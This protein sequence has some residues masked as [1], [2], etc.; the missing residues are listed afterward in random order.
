[1]NNKEVSPFTPGN[2]VPVEFFVGRRDK[3]EEIL[4]YIKQTTSGKQEN[5]FLSGERSI[6]KSSLAA[7]I[8]HFAIAKENFIGVH[9]FLGGVS[10]L[11]ELVRRIFDQLLKETRGQTLFNNII[12]LF[13][14]HIKEIGLFG[15][16]VSFN[17]PKEDLKDLVLNFSSALQNIIKKVKNE[18][19]GLFITLDD[20][21]GLA[22]NDA[23][24]NW[25][26]SFV[27]EVATHYSYFPVFIMTVGL[28]E[29]RDS[30]SK[31]QPS[32]M[33]I[34]RVVEI[35]KLQDKEVKEFFLRTFNK[36]N[37]KVES[38]AMEIMIDFSSGLPIL[39]QEIGDACFWVDTDGVIKKEDVFP[40][41]I[42]ASE[43][44]GKKYLEPQVY[45]AIQS[46]RYKS[47]LRKLV[48]SPLSRYLKKQDVEK[49]LNESEKKV[50][51]HFLRKM[52]NLGIISYDRERGYSF[53]NA[54]Y[55]VF[56]Y[57]E[58]QLYLSQK[59]KKSKV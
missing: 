56:I 6:G 29:V 59:Y 22:K 4:H 51:H 5:V 44:I 23:F 16:S 28:P 47:I 33:R 55:P 30:L 13:G 9:I 42:L 39:M 25:Y 2:P 41:I 57:F 40:G 7:F 48:E 15:I 36:V 46:E 12:E 24:A 38:D 54:I 18:K 37:M 53:V 34:F 49:R 21:N 43:R 45:R 52:R 27:D 58:S 14:E 17:P 20:I 50:F 35:D 8:R 3:I 10:T 32:L 19:R 1:M 31:L 26:K 11:E